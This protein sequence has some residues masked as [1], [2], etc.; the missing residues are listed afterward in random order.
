MEELSLFAKLLL[1]IMKTKKNQED[2]DRLLAEKLKEH[3][4]CAYTLHNLGNVYYHQEKYPEAIN[5]YKQ[6]LDIYEKTVGKE[7]THYA[8]TLNNLG[9]SI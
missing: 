3:V 8:N 6:A 4:K 9:D 5:M 7:S 2:A 1:L